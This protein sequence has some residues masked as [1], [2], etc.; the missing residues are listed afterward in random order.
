MDE[1]TRIIAVVADTHIP[2]RVGGLHPMLLLELQAL[3]PDLILHAGDICAPA[4]LE[5]LKQIAPVEAVRGNRDWLFVKSL[6]LV[7]EFSV[8]GV[9]IALQHGHGT[10]LDYLADKWEYFKQGYRLERYLRI[11]RRSANNA[12]V[13]VFGHT[14]YAECVWENNVLLFNPGSASMPPPRKWRPTFG[15]LRISADGHVEAEIRPLEGYRRDGH[16]WVNIG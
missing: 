15:V 7:R 3:Q 2:D 16:R 12:T 14:H 8:N 13:L 6:P 5:S 4:V 1:S 11:V 9:R 10:F